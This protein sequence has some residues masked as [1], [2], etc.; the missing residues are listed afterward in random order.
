MPKENVEWITSLLKSGQSIRSI[1]AQGAS[2]Y[3]GA[4]LSKIH[5]LTERYIR[6]VVNDAMTTADK[7]KTVLKCPSDPPVSAIFI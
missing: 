6:Y 4:P 3:L 2:Q 1:I 7:K 5:M